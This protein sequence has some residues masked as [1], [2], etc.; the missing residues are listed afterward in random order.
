MVDSRTGV[1]DET[2][3]S[4]GVTKLESA[5]KLKG[6]RNQFE[7]VPNGQIWANVN[8]EMNNNSNGFQAID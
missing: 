5:Q 1:R 2:R 8:N 4:C 6:H 3:T 7:G